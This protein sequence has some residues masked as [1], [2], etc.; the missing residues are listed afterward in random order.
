VWNA[1]IDFRIGKLVRVGDHFAVQAVAD[2][3]PGLIVLVREDGSLKIL[4][5]EGTQ[6]SRAWAVSFGPGARRPVSLSLD[7][8]IG[9]ELFGYRLWPTSGC[10]DGSR[11]AGKASRRTSSPSGPPREDRST[12]TV[13]AHTHALSRARVRRERKQGS[14]RCVPDADVAL[15]WMRASTPPVPGSRSVPASATRPGVRP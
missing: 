11:S 6:G 1:K 3:A 2:G 13:P 7:P 14:R 8:K 15:S 5:V 10:P 12:F 4:A 9:S